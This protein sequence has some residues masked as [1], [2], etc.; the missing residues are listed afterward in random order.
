MMRLVKRGLMFGNL[1]AVTSP[2]LVTRYNR[3]LDH[4]AGRTTKLEEFHID[5][6]GYSPEIGD[7][8]NDLLYLNPNGCNRQF[9]LL[10]TEQKSGPLLN[11]KFSNSHSIMRSFISQNEAQLFSLT[12]REAVAGEL[13]NSI[14]SV[15]KPSDLFNIREIEI[16]ADTVTS[17]VATSERLSKK[18]E[19]F[20]T[21]RDAWWDD[22]LA[23][24]MIELAKR[25]GDIVRHPVKLTHNR[26]K[27]DNFYTSHFGGLYVLRDMEEPGCIAFGD[28][29]KLGSLPIS[30]VFGSHE[31]EDIAEFLTEND[32]VE[33]IVSAHD[34][35]AA[36][37]LKQ[38]LDFIVV[39][40]AAEVGENLSNVTRQNLRHLKRK[41]IKDLPDEFHGLNALWLW[42]TKQGPKPRIDPEDPVYFYTLRSSHHR[43]KYLIN[44][45][46]AQL[47]PMDFRQLF[48][49]H[50]AAFYAAY[51]TWS[52]QKKE[53]VAR[54]LEAEYLIDKAGARR[55]L[56]GPEPNMMD[57]EFETDTI[58][59]AGHNEID[60]D[61]DVSEIGA[62][63]LR[64]GPWGPIPVET[65]W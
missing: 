47:T 25:T 6:S 61:D 54:F 48:I 44:M 35:D 55:D 20:M 1:F 26:F 43:D 36:A 42:V 32:L 16:E 24:E 65:K 63:R 28:T 2:T 30:D 34:M 45:L 10:S 23:A 31:R 58:I 39:N 41:L 19:T 17:H 3:A 60:V 62:P 40:T 50:K 59:D 4:L 12:A 51:R 52:D 33:E 49:C 46:L 18:I 64:R 13:V 57:D 22:V 53:Y 38:K 8:F 56:F 27:Q 29:D 7:E 14:F 9:I 15:E 37:V 21:K 11:A 5:I